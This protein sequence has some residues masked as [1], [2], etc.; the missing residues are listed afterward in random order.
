MA[1]KGRSVADDQ[2]VIE[3]AARLDV[4]E[5]E[6]DAAADFLLRPE[7]SVPRPRWYAPVA[8]DIATVPASLVPRAR[9]LLERQLKVIHEMEGEVE[10]VANELTMLS[11]HHHPPS[12]DETPALYFDDLA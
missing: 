12:T 4:L 3:W 10:R 2:L 9:R 7:G 6:L 5:N 11:G 1:S 8:D